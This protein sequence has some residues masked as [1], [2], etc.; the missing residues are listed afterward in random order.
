[1]NDNA[2]WRLLR[3]IAPLGGWFA[4]AALLGVATIGSSVGLIATSAYLIA[5]AA[6]A[7]SIAELQI[8]I[9]GVRFFGIARGVLRYLERYAAHSATFRLLARLRVWFYQA[10]EPLA[11]AGLLR[12]RSGDLLTRV[13]ADVD[14]L[15]QFFIRAVAPPV[16]ALLVGGMACA[17]VGLFDIWLGLA[18]LLALLLAGAGLP[19]LTLRLSRGPGERIVGARAELSAALLDGVQGVA[20]LLAFG[21]AERHQAEVDRL[22]ERLARAQ[23]R[24]AAI[25]GM[26]GALT[27]LLASLAG[28]ALLA[29]ATPLVRGGWLDGVYLALIVLTAGAAFEAVAP[30]SQAAQHLASS[31]AAARRIFAIADSAPPVEDPADPAPALLH[32]GLEVRDLSFAYPTTE[33]QEPRINLAQSALGSRFLVLDRVSFCLPPG[34]RLAIVGASGAGKSTL[35]HLLLRFWEY[36][37]GQV[38]LG[39]YELRRYRAD[40]VRQMVSVVSQ[41]THLFN[42]TIRE[43]LWVAR[44]GASQ[45]ELVAAAQQAQ[46]DRFI[47]GLPQ[48]YDT[49][50]GEGGTRLS[51]GERQRLAIARAF[52]KDSPLLFLDEPTANLDAIAER[53]I[54]QTLGA[55]MA[56]PTTLLITHRLVGLERFDGILVLDRG[57]VVEQG[58]HHDLLVRGGYYRRMWEQQ[59]SAPLAR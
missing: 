41:D 51:G 52:L 43:N 8:A 54:M 32:A 7:P 18:L 28:L 33:N 1:M 22:G 42:S 35:L 57:R 29:I 2:L 15:E 50:I 10:V 47:Q 56:R 20:D 6:L 44:P 11:P 27:G 55:L 48:G 58:S 26:H 14:T 39:G 36:Q 34:G 19:V 31:R 38:L 40:D 59:A 12:Y 13:V 4:L 30:L 49:W 16:V 25:R 21:Q 45:D 24:M 9:V 5:K 17:L 53:E 23:E 46:I 37:H 3:L